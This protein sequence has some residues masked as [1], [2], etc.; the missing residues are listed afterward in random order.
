[1]S[2]RNAL[3]VVLCTLGITGCD[4]S[5]ED[6][7]AADK[8]VLAEEKKLTELQGRIRQCYLNIEQAN[9]EIQGAPSGAAS[10]L[11]RLKNRQPMPGE[12]QSFAA[13]IARQEAEIDAALQLQLN[14]S[15]QKLAAYEK[16]MEAAKADVEAQKVV[17]NEARLKRQA[18]M[19]KQ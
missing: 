16:D 4:T 5:K 13:E 7:S 8:V 17:V 12:E 15:K 10:A 14:E 9:R 18:L 3:F 11:F 19:Q 2:I 6:Y 1:M